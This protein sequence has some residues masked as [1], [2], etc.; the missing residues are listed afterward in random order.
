MAD[1]RAFA[2]FDVG[3]LDNPKIMDVFDASPIAVCMH[4][5]SVLYCAQHLTDGEI[6]L[7]AMQRKCGGTSDDSKLLIDA[8]LWHLPGHDCP[9]CPDPKPGKAYVHDY[10]QHNRTSDGVKGRSE[11]GKIAAEARWAKQKAD[12]KRNAEANANRIATDEES[13]SELSGSAMPRQTEEKDRKTSLLKDLAKVKDEFITWYAEYPLKQAKQDAER[14]YIK[15]RK[16]V[17]AETLMVGMLRYRDDPNRDPG[18]TKQPATWLNKGCWDDEPIQ[19][20]QGTA[21]PSGSQIRANAGLA[22]IAAYG[23]PAAPTQLELGA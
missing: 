15:A 3:Y 21:R 20:P 6:A 19:A 13:Q 4:F 17:S 10:L 14:A 12:A 11:A 23:P 2:V 8:G 5:A 16:T 1:K 7:R 22:R 18:F 9:S